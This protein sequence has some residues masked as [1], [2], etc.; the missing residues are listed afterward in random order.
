MT[1]TVTD[2][3]TGPSERQVDLN[4]D[5]GEGFG[6]WSMGDDAALL[7][8]VTSANV[9]CGFHAGDPRTMRRVCSLA[10]EREV[11]IGAHVSYRDLAGFGRRNL[12]VDPGELRDEVTYQVAG[13]DGMARAAGTRVRY[14]KAHGALYNRAAHDEVHAQAL[15]DGVHAYDPRL[16]LLGLPGSVVL[17]LAAR[18]GLRAVQEA[19]PDRAYTAEGRLAPRSGAD[20]VLH[21]PEL[22]AQ[23]AVRMALGDEVVAATG[24]VVALRSRSLCVHGDSPGAVA[25]AGRIREALCAAGAALVPFT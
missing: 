24:E 20:S 11:R 12:E 22:V 25:L 7:A 1:D 9:A 3:T 5:L 21:D 8:I 6:A 17:T 15:V 13:L 19:F 4:A 23:R 10:A 18:A 2:Q 16:P 14:V